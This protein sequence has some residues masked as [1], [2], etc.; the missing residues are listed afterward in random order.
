[1]TDENKNKQSNYICQSLY[2]AKCDI[3]ARQ[4]FYNAKCDI[5]VK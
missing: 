1:M 4:S 3:A 2:N 5:A